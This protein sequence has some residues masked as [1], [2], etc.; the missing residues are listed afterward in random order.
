[1]E[2]I[3]KVLQQYKRNT[4]LS[5]TIYHHFME[6]LEASIHCFSEIEGTGTTFEFLKK[7]GVKIG[8]GSG[9]PL[10]FMQLIVQ[11]LGWNPLTF[12]YM[13]SSDQLPEGRPS[14]VMI[15]DA[16]DKLG[17]SNPEFILKIGDTK[18]DILEG[19]NASA[20]T[21]WVQTG[22]QRKEDLDGLD[23]DFIFNDVGEIIQLFQTI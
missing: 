13:N 4:A 20:K 12:D 8:I 17:I 18:V 2:A 5:A 21:A 19:K 1:M 9:L 16:M 23:P 15:T 3:S 11:H 6:Q 22:T 7:K 10:S 14:P